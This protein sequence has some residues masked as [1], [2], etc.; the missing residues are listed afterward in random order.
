MNKTQVENC[1]LNVIDRVTAGRPVEDSRVEL[2][3][4]WPDP[5][6]AARQIGAHANASC[7]EGFLAVIRQ[8]DADRY[9]QVAKLPTGKLARTCFFDADTGRLFLAVPRY[10]GKEGPEI[11]VYR[12]RP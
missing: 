12:A 8:I 9:E 7:G 6:K 1:I 2:K 5:V 4:K 11:W 10:K 3:A